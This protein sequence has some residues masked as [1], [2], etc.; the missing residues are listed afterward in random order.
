MKS[1][2]TGKTIVEDCDQCGR[3][4]VFEGRDNT[5]RYRG[6]VAGK[7]A[8]LRRERV[9]V[10]TSVACAA[11]RLVNDISP[12]VGS[13]RSSAPRGPARGSSRAACRQPGAGNPALVRTG[14][15][16]GRRHASTC[17]CARD[18]DHLDTGR[19]SSARPRIQLVLAASMR[20]ER[21]HRAIGRGQNAWA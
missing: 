15:A 5:K 21:G 19:G 12:L 1:K 18:L 14:S 6:L 3:C 4:R 17:L 11:A 9:R 16:R 20:V 8:Q 7:A 2:S 13:P 10:S